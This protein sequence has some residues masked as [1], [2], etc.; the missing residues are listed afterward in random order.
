[1]ERM[2]SSALWVWG[3]SVA[4][5]VGG[6]LFWVL[7]AGL[8]GAASV[9][10]AAAEVGFGVFLSSLLNFGFAQY[11][12][13]E[14]PERGGSALASGLLASAG[15]GLGA[16]AAGLIA[17]RPLGGA[18]ALANLVL[19]TALAGLVAGGRPR[20][21]FAV[22][23]FNAFFKLLLLW[24]LRDAVLSVA[25]SAA[26]S[27]VL[28]ASLALYV[29]GVGRPG[30]WRGVFAAGAGN[31]W[32]N[33]SAGFAVSAGVVLAERVA[34]PAAAGV[35]YLTAMA[36]LVVGSFA[37]SLSTSGIPVM[38]RL[39]TAVAERVTRVGMGATVPLV[40]AASALAGPLFGLLGRDF[41]GA[42]PSLAL[43][44]VSAAELVA[45]NIAV[46]VYNVERSWGRLAALGLV[47]SASLV[48]SSA[49]LSGLAPWG[50]GAALAL[51][52]LPGFLLAARD[53]GAYPSLA[54]ASVAL[55]F[56]VLGLL[57]GP[58]WAAPLALASLLSLHLIGVVRVGEL[59]GLARAALRL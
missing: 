21:Y 51:G 9:G 7:V 25:L 39:G 53:V 40:A 58:L 38:A 41:S 20:L 37:F 8:G 59:L 44:L 27:A 57:L 17:G 52:F 45:V 5:S 12:L 23:V 35:F 34:G 14:V 54:G 4:G 47:S 29:V 24:A 19:N 49:L 3:A 10:S 48:A 42:Y 11:V 13:R 18:L 46:A 33:F 6:L 50:P 32:N 1:M 36:A 15:V 31:Y 55:L 16:F 26:L 22:G 30:N 43:G 56:S 28:G 2:L